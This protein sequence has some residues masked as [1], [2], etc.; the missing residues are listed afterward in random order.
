MLYAEED[1]MDVIQSLMVSTFHT[2]DASM[3]LQ[4]DAGSYLPGCGGSGRRDGPP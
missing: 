3:A 4:I 2:M 1:P